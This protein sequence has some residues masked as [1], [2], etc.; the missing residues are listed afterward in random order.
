MQTEPAQP[1]Y[2]GLTRYQW[3]VLLVAWMGW[4]FDIADS[5]IFGLAKISMLTEILGADVYAK[6][7]KDIEANIQMWFLIGLSIG[8]LV[9][10]VLADKWGRT[11]TLILTVLMYSILTA[12]TSMVHTVEQLT[13]LRFLTALGI[14]GELGAGR[15]VGA[16]H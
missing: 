13:L 11:R 4:V 8:G 2:R 15:D 14:G 10:G 12:A 5:A 7:G 1:W 6:V 16:A 9:F 3:I